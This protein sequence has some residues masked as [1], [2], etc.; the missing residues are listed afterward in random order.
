MTTRVTTVT[1]TMSDADSLLWTIGRDPVLLPTIVA[2]ALLD[3]VPRWE[4]VQKRFFDLATM[5]PSLR[6]RAVSL[7]LGLWR[8]RWIDDGRFDLDEHVRRVGAPPPA[9]V[10][11]VL[12]LAQSMASS[13]FHSDVPPW[14]ALVVE[15]LEGGAAAL[16]VKLH[17]A[18]VDGVG[19]IEVLLHLLDTDRSGRPPEER[20]LED[21]TVGV[22]PPVAPTWR[23]EALPAD[24]RG[25]SLPAKLPDLLRGPR[26]LAS[27]FVRDPVGHLADAV[28]L[29]TSVARLLAPAGR[30][31]SKLTAGRST[32]RA[33]EVID[34][35]Y[36]G[37]RNAARLVGGTVN[38]AFVAG[39]VMGLRRYHELHS[40]PIG[41]LRVL[42]P[43]NVRSDGQP[44]AGNHFVPARFVLPVPA[45]AA[46]CLREVHRIAG[47]F[48]NDPA[49]A[50]TD[51]LAAGLD[52]LPGR[53]ATFVWGSMLKGD[54]FCATNVP[55]PS[56]ETYL[57]GARVERLYA[58][59]PPSGAAMNVSLLTP[60]RR[61]C[62]GVNLDSAAVP[63]PAKLASCLEEGFYEVMHLDERQKA[64]EEVEA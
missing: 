39:I 12:D 5:L 11:S 19:G 61:A 10:R 1:G 64:A 55:G 58:F 37:L 60:G 50:L 62:V 18:L 14:E 44:L 46:E 47:S 34:L 24:R 45:D 22:H 7:P 4:I 52:L 42:M 40:A 16:V 54:D 15:G 32:G 27:S 53:A 2:V 35:P 29:T 21:R 36:D 26:R 8:P 38:D 3:R 33:F 56:F 28:S 30:P 23:A 51:V 43:I 9:R 41:S 25:G 49:L 17:H 59:A 13:G 20:A 31:R 57:A 48:K 63:D 6:S